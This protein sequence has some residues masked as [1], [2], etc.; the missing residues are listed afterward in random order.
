LRI[1]IDTDVL[2]DVALDRKPHATASGHLLDYLQ[3]RPGTGCFAWHTASNFYYL[4]RE[5]RSGTNPH[6]FLASLSSFLDVAPTST[7]TLRFALHLDMT[8]FEDAMQVA[9]ASAWGADV[10]ATRNLQDFRKSP[11]PA[12]S[13]ASLLRM[14][15]E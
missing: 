13:P 8:D 2:L 7:P 9:A 14:T 11:I 15:K 6:S 5:G 4:T 3:R 12:Q 1:L 10:I